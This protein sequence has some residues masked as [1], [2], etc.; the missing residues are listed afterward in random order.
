MNG[1]FP[2]IKKLLAE[3]RSLLALMTIALAGL[4]WFSVYRTAFAEARMKST[5]SGG[6]SMRM[7]GFL[8]AVGGPNMDFSTA[9]FEALNLYWL[10]LL[11][12]LLLTMV[13]AI[14]RGSSGIAGELEKGSVDLILS[15]PVARGVFFMSQVAVVLI[16]FG[17]MIAAILIGNLIGS[18]FNKVDTPPPILGVLRPAL[19]MV[20]VGYAIFGYTIFFSSMDLVR[21]RPNL[22]AS[23]ITLAQF[24]ALAIG[25]QPDWDR[26]KWLNKMSVF[27]AFQP[28]EAAVKGELLASHIGILALVGTIGIILGFIIF[29]QR[30]LPASGG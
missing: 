18:Q 28:I 30:D 8:R 11:I 10:S 23:S 3:S 19:N 15:R 7:Q 17:I 24:I 29:Q 6:M 5:E 16:G 20:F 12:P 1:F 25:N 13:W 2:L 22:L 4:S 27:A 26:W 9:A 21:W 14:S